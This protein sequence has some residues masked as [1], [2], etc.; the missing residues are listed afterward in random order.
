MFINISLLVKYIS[1]FD[2]MNINISIVDIVAIFLLIFIYFK[3]DIKMIRYIMT[4][5]VS[6]SKNVN[7]EG[8]IV[9]IRG[10][11]K[12][13]FLTVYVDKIRIKDNFVSS[14]G[15]NEK[16]NICI[17][18]FEPFMERPNMRTYKSSAIDSIYIV[19]ICFLIYLKFILDISIKNMWEIRRIISCL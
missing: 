13:L 7:I 17:H 11:N 8:I 1:M 15:W 2:E 16:F 3:S 12:D 14:L 18:A 9:K 5:P 6:G 10:I 19:G 4:E